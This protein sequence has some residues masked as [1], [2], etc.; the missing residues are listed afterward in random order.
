LKETKSKEKKKP[1]V[2]LSCAMTID[3]K[4]ATYS[5]DAELSDEQDWKEVHKL[6]KEFD[7]IMVGKQTILND[8]P[9]LHIKY[10]KPSRLVR[11]VVD[12][13]FN[14]P[15]NSNVINFKPDIYPTIVAV[16]SHAPKTK[17]DEAKKKNITI[18]NT[19]N[20]KQ[21]N[22]KRLMLNLYQ[23]DIKKL[24][25]EGGATLNWSML[26]QGLVDEIR[27]SIAPIIVGGKKA[28]SLVEGE[29]VKKMI[30]GFKFR[31]SQVEKREDYVILHYLKK[32]GVG[33]Q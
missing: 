16:T 29:G 19:G 3:G 15:L 30:D 8:D 21:V 25:I 6:R 20:E 1:Y 22:L 32:I 17:I 13:N 33:D 26:S 4:I 27:V 12:S 24:I 11:V 23:L 14:I 18:I 10:Y 2:L 31:L 28:I 7:A 5:G 9:K